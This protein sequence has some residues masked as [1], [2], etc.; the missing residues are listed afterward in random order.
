M[1]TRNHATRQ[2]HRCGL[3]EVVK[4]TASAARRETRNHTVRPRED[5]GAQATNPLSHRPE[6]KRGV[7]R[8]NESI[9][10]LR[11]K[12]LRNSS[13]LLSVP[14]GKCA[15]ASNAHCELQRK[16]QQG[17]TN[18]D[19]VTLHPT[20]TTNCIPPNKDTKARTR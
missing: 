14:C 1:G 16:E 8:V 18:S 12:Y 19:D 3:N 13:F 9:T 20:I 15:V 4:A 7:P 11:S 10:P 2:G 6:R 17:N 5:A